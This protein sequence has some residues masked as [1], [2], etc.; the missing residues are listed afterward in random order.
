MTE[1]VGISVIHG[2]SYL[3]N[4][5]RILVTYYFNKEN[6]VRYITGTIVEIGK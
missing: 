4:E 1:E 5:N 6:G 2:L 3:L